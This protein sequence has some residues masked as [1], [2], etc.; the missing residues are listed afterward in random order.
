MKT[1]SASRVTSVQKTPIKSP[2]IAK[3]VK[4]K[5]KKSQEVLYISPIDPQGATEIRGEPL[6][7]E[8][9]IREFKKG[10]A[11]II[12]K[13]SKEISGDALRHL[14]RFASTGNMTRIQTV[15][16][17]LLVRRRRKTIQKS[18]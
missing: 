13:I 8:G 7:E 14:L 6:N 4:Q 16:G 11:E 10:F 9:L 18:L 17:L 1:R 5:I 2:L 12:H 3:K 15:I